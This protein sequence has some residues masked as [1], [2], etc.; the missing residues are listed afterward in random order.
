MKSSSAE[1]ASDEEAQGETTA[2]ETPAPSKALRPVRSNRAM[3]DSFDLYLLYADVSCTAAPESFLKSQFLFVLLI[4][5]LGQCKSDSAIAMSPVA[6]FLL[7]LQCE[8]S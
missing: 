4:R 8:A 5:P 7:Q 3:Y 2:E 6:Y 1:V